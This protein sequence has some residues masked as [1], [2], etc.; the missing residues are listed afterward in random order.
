MEEGGDERRAEKKRVGIARGEVEDRG[1][2][3]EGK[4]MKV[5]EEKGERWEGRVQSTK[6]PSPGGQTGF[7]SFQ[8]LSDCLGRTFLCQAA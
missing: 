1:E 5:L 7:L 6:F 8:T 3:E 2:E 4:E